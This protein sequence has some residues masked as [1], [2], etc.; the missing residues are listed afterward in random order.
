MTTNH[1]CT[2]YAAFLRRLDARLGMALYPDSRNPKKGVYWVTFDLA[3]NTRLRITTLDALFQLI[4][5]RSASP[6]PWVCEALQVLGYERRVQEARQQFRHAERLRA[7]LS[8]ERAAAT[9]QS[10]TAYATPA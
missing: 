2:R 10:L 9:G 4:G 8:A 3:G 5:V 1:L 7:M 6:G